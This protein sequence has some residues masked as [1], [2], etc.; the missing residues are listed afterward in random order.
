MMDRGQARLP[1]MV[2]ME[3]SRKSGKGLTTLGKGLTS[4]L[5]P[6]YCRVCIRPCLTL[7]SGMRR[8]TPLSSRMPTSVGLPSCP[9]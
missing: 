7:L 8:P 4:L 2:F 1:L 3:V 6:L 5:T 9:P